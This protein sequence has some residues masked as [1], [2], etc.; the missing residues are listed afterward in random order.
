MSTLENPNVDNGYLVLYRRFLKHL[1]ADNGY[2]LLSS[3]IL[4]SS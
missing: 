2:V 3:W 1:K 4:D